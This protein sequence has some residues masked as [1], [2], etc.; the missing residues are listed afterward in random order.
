MSTEYKRLDKDLAAVLL[1]DH[2]TGLFS[3]VRDIDPDQF[4][5]NVLALAQAGAKPVSCVQLICESQR[6]W[7]RKDPA[8]E[9]ANI[10]FS[11]AKPLTARVDDAA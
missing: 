8:P 6:D 7:A 10:L 11:V 4:R 5:N 9:F 3:L 1:V 2:Q